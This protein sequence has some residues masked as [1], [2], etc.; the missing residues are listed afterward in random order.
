MFGNSNMNDAES[1]PL[2][3]S[4]PKEFG[5]IFRAECEA[6]GMTQQAVAREAQCRRHHWR[7]G[8]WQKRGVDDGFYGA[9][10]GQQILGD[11]EQPPRAGGCGQVLRGGQRCLM[12]CK[13]RSLRGQ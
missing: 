7:S 3:A 8:G 12:L 13:V 1:T 4:T 9:Q 6:L 5:E 10:R 11:Q 2:K